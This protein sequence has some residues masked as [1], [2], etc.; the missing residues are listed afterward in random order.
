MAGPAAIDAMLGERL[1]GVLSTGGAVALMVF[2]L[3]YVPC[4]ATLA[5]LRRSFGTRWMLV[6]VGYQF[7]VA[8]L[9]A[10]AVFALWP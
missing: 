2:M 8:Y 5:A 10:W 7:G 6:S 1:A 9:A 3:L 4:V